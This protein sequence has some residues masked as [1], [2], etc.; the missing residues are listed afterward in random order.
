MN[1]FSPPTSEGLAYRAFREWAGHW[2]NQDTFG[3]KVP[4][5]HHYGHTSTGGALIIAPCSVDEVVLFIASRPKDS[6][7]RYLFE[8]SDVG[9]EWLGHWCLFTVAPIVSI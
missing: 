8:S 6:D 1:E 5:L 3:H 7:I 9:P 2:I 4:P